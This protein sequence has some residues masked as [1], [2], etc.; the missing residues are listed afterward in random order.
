[1][2]N[3]KIACGIIILGLAFLTGCGSKLP[4]MT[5]DQ[6]DQIV[7]YAANIVARYMKDYDSRLVD[8]S[9]YD[10]QK[11]ETGI[12]GEQQTEPEGMDPTVDTPIIDTIEEESFGTLE[13]L[14][15]EGISITYAGSLITDSYPNT[16]DA[17]PYLEAY[18]GMKFLVLKFDLQNTSG[19]EIKINNVSSGFRC[20]VKINN[21][22]QVK[23]LSTMLLDDLSNY[24][25]SLNAGEEISL[26]LLVEVNED[27]ADR[28]EGLQL[29]IVTEAGSETVLLQ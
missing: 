22:D 28:I 9:L 23:I 2:N 27:I 6:K 20:T 29:I 8:L 25:G 14:V 11:V 13:S 7:E 26:I 3:K 4:Q 16:E 19:E 18:E 17:N 1:M 5:E 10:E 15:P 21:T 24:V 12:E